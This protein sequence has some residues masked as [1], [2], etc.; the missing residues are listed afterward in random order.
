M[1]AIL[2]TTALGSDERET[3]GDVV[4]AVLPT[5]ESLDGFKGVLVLVDEQANV[6]HGVTLW[7]GEDHLQ[8]AEPVLRRIREAET[9][10]RHVL[11]QDTTMLSVAALHLT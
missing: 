4:G 9:R 11:H 3:W 7:E 1:L 2:T 6:V 10:N 8:R 5:L